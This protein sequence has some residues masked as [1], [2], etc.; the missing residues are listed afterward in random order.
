MPNY[1]YRRNDYLAHVFNLWLILAMV[2]LRLDAGL[3]GGLGQKGGEG[4]S[5]RNRLMVNPERKPG[6]KDDHPGRH[7]AGVDSSLA[8]TR[9]TWRQLYSL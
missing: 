7:V 2:S 8:N 1:E 3:G 5:C 6:N 4:D 9:S